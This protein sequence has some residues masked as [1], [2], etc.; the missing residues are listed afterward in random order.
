MGNVSKAGPCFGWAVFA[1]GDCP[2]GVNAL[3][4][5]PTE[6]YW[7]LLSNAALL[8]TEAAE[9]LVERL[10]TWLGGKY[11][12][13]SSGTDRPPANDYDL[14][15]ALYIRGFTAG[16]ATAQHAVTALLSTEAE[17]VSDSLPL[18]DGTIREEEKP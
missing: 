15:E 8:G 11:V 18:L 1:W 14:C 12:F 9:A 5:M 10:N 7:R 17:A 16:Y 3:F 13:S 2:Q 6:R 4:Q